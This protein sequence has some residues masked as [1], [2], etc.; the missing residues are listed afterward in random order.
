MPGTAADASSPL[1][2][3]LG[4]AFSS[5]AALARFLPATCFL[6]VAPFAAALTGA[7]AG[8]KPELELDVAM[9]STQKRN[10]TFKSPRW[11]MMTEKQINLRRVE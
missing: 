1:A 5:A 7:G 9:L 6:G 10:H 8:L 2:F 4:V 3:L 11:V